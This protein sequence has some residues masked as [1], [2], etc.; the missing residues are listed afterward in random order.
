MEFKR[1]LRCPPDV[2]SEIDIFVSSTGNYQHQ[3]FGP[4]KKLKNVSL[5]GNTG[6]F[7]NELD[8]AGSEGLDG[9]K[10]VNIKPH[11]DPFVFP[12][13]LSLSHFPEQLDKKVATLQLPAL[14]A[15]ITVCAKEHAVYIG[16][17][18]EGS[19][20]Q[21]KSSSYM[22]VATL[23]PLRLRSGVHCLSPVRRS[24]F[25]FLWRSMRKWRTTFLHF[26]RRST[27]LIH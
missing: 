10:V 4:Q 12:V 1:A 11:V 3:R 19:F 22:F 5:V 18:F 14:G 16:V 7:D 24:I 13:V 15:A 21:C 6:Y 8:F 20:A 2:M 25:R 9:V 26:V 23:C 27:S 17:K